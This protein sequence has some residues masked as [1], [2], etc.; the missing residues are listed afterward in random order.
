EDALDVLVRKWRDPIEQV[1]QLVAVLQRHN[2]GLEREHL[3]ELDET[4]AQILEQTTESLRSCEPDEWDDPA[5]PRPSGPRDRADEAVVHE[6]A[7]HM[8]QPAQL[9]PA[10]HSRASS[11][12]GR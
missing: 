10:G 2:V 11:A 3:A 1:E 8:Q 5:R 9:P 6:H 7:Q 4:A 12:T